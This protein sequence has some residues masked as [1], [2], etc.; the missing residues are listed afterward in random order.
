MNLTV[1]QLK[2]VEKYASLF[3]SPYEI[4]VLID[5]CPIQFIK[6]LQSIKSPL[7]LAYNKGK[8][9]TKAEIR[10]KVVSHAKM[11]SPTA[12]ALAEKYIEEQKISEDVYYQ[13]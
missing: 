2:N 9:R 13:V 3:L 7:A 5:E 8:T 4:A 1:D 6:E 12:Q 11:G 10:E